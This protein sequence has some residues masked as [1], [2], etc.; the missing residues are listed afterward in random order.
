MMISSDGN[1]NSISTKGYFTRGD[2]SRQVLS[3]LNHGG[4]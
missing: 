3:K 1:N 2:I 4:K